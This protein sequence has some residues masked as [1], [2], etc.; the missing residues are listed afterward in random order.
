MLLQAS[1]F[2]EA[3]S[4]SEFAC[5]T[6][7]DCEGLI[8]SPGF[9]DVQFNGGWGVDFS[10]PE[11]TEEDILRVCTL[12]LSTGVTGI[13]PTLVSSG[14]ELY[15]K[16]IATFKSLSKRLE[17]KNFVAVRE[18]PPGPGSTAS[19]AVAA[20]AA[21]S[22]AD[23]GIRP[24][25]RLLGLHLEG[26]FLHPDRRGAHPLH[27]LVTPATAL[28]LNA[29]AAAH[30]GAQD[31]SPAAA[32]TPKS[33]GMVRNES[34]DN[35]PADIHRQLAKLA[36]KGSEPSQNS[37]EQEEE[38]DIAATEPALRGMRR[39]YGPVEWESGDVRIVTVAPELPGAL[40]AITALARRGI[41]VSVGHTTAGIRQADAA[42]EA[43]ATKVTHL[44][45]A[46]S[47]FHHRDPG[48]VGLLG[49]NPGGA[50]HRRKMR[51]RLSSDGGKMNETGGRSLRGITEEPYASPL[52]AGRAAPLTGLSP[53]ESMHSAE[54]P[55][56]ARLPHLPV[57]SAQGS[58]S[59]ITGAFARL[60]VLEHVTP[61]TAVPY[62]PLG[63]EGR[64][65]GE[66]G[67]NG[68]PGPIR[69]PGSG[70]AQAPS[71]NRNSVKLSMSSSFH[72]GADGMNGS[73]VGD[74][75]S[76]RL[77]AGG[78]N[79]RGSSED[80]KGETEPLDLHSRLR[81][82]QMVVYPRLNELQ[83][84][85]DQSPT[86]AA[87]AAA[88]AAMPPRG[89]YATSTTSASFAL[90]SHGPHSSPPTSARGPEESFSLDRRADPDGSPREDAEGD[91]DGL[92]LGLGL[93]LEGT[94]GAQGSATAGTLPSLSSLLPHHANGGSST[95]Q[96]P[97]HAQYAYAYRGGGATG[98]AGSVGVGAARTA[99]G[100]SAGYYAGDDLPPLPT[101]YSRPYY[102]LIADGVHVHPYAVCMAHETHPSGLILVTDAMQAL[103]LP[104]GRHTLG[105]MTVDIH[106]G[107]QDGHYEGLHA[108]LAGTSTL[109]GAVVPL[110]QCIRNFC[111]FT[112]VPLEKALP[113]VTANPSKLLRLDGILGFLSVGAWADMVLLSDDGQVLQTWMGGRLA[114]KA[115]Y[116]KQKK[117]TLI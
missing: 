55:P 5:D 36:L 57:V 19:S 21:P 70:R 12:L 110:D 9:L 113:S 26:P 87:N 101:V 82:S 107:A 109:A 22:A 92:G 35:L 37:A 108:V 18:T 116:G 102:G 8:L 91:G 83:T 80:L 30:A 98:G 32:G 84:L 41:V 103:G 28:P 86:L 33:A 43:G 71:S 63:W 14:P 16:V 67:Q 3:A 54:G 6:I 95:P 24:G 112:G 88:A 53:N 72:E 44:F 25:A 46:M 17:E 76:S 117:A 96:A 56:S 97:E 20:A 93:G 13:C 115:Q 39:I 94:A 78:G 104:I 50:Q 11:V 105:E 65:I 114:Y 4:F 58:S 1:R 79:G 23:D 73:P 66:G 69:V 40:E 2:W 15:R 111:D 61:Y 7:V 75:N 49:R 38:A 81:G 31:G 106:M 90:P 27:N 34:A 89:P 99:T 29:V 68:K 74:L 10:D 48:V 51:R 59:P 60:A 64:E 100:G 45:N 77:G 85:A 52:L 42:L 47:A 62:R